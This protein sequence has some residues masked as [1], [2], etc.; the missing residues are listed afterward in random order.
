M[1]KRKPKS[2][3]S[4]DFDKTFNSATFYDYQDSENLNHTS[5]EEALESFLDNH[6]EKGKTLTKTIE[7]LSPIEIHAYK[8][9]PVDPEGVKSET[10]S[11][12][13]MF[14]DYLD[15]EYGDAYRDHEV[16][17]EKQIK[18]IITELTPIMLK[19][20]ARADPWRCKEVASRD[21]SAKEIKALMPE[22]FE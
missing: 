15:D 16:L 19:W 8:K 17:S 11:M 7:E 10:K 2:K 13:E 6:Y 5:P 14:R 9:T 12:V 20:A 18:Q 4:E 3:A 1:G 21:Y 22:W